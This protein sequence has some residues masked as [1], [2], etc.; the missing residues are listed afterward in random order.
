MH[1]P[2]PL[3]SKRSAQEAEVD[4]AGQSVAS[5]DAVS[6]SAHD[7]DS[8]HASCAGVNDPLQTREQ[9]E[10]TWLDGAPHSSAFC[11]QRRWH[12]VAFVPPLLDDELDDDDDDA[13]VPV[14]VTVHA[15]TVARTPNVSARVILAS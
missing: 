13:P 3:Q 15:A 4:E 8:M 1:S 5:E 10:S 14:V 6:S 9:S 11:T 7:F 12:S 2:R